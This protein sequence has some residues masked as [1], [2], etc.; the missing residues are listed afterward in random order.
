VR[1]AFEVADVI[2]SHWKELLYSQHFNAWQSRTLDAIRRC[3]TASLGGHVDLCTSCSHIR[4]SYNSCRNRHCPKCQ[5][6]QRERWIQAREAELLPTA[7]FHVVFTLPEALNRLC[8]FEPEKVYNILFSTAW[9]VMKSFAATPEHLGA[10]TGMIAVLHTWGQNLS[11]HPHLH[12]IVPAGGLTKAGFWKQSRGDGDF[13]F[14]VKSMSPVFRARF[15]AT[16]RQTFKL[17][18]VF[19][20][21]LF[22]TNWIVYAKQAFGGPKQVIEYLGR[23]THKIAISNH[24]IMNITESA[25]TFSYKDYRQEGVKKVMTL[26]PTEFT[27][28]FSL[29]ILPK[30]FVRIRHYG[31]LSSSRKLD[32]LPLIHEQLHSRY[33][34]PQHRDTEQIMLALGFNPVCC[35][36]CN[37]PTMVTILT[38]DRRGPPDNDHL[39]RIRDKVLKNRRTEITQA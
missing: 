33:V 14:P 1:P 16:L 17:D 29:H 39:I 25:V 34:P 37:E 36:H 22:K 20:D 38:F 8:L 26:T 12:C 4:I 21:A 7:Y 15:V 9:S 5:Q 10:E 13:L 28:R 35:P 23:Y 32:T 18:R 6:V 31:I 30:G 2:N 3:R 19:Y 11:L 24:R 27:R